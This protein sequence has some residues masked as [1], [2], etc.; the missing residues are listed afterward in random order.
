M[1]DNFGGRTYNKRSNE[2]KAGPSKEEKEKRE[3]AKEVTCY[4]C[5]KPSPICDVPKPGGP[6]TTRQPAEYS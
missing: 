5:K 4:N 3:G 2:K 1:K 6:L